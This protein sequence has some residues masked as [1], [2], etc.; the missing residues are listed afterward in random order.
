M[1]LFEPEAA[2]WMVDA[3]PGDF[4]FG[5]IEPDWERMAPFV[6]TAMNR[7]PVSLDAGVKK[8]FCG[9]ESFTPD[10]APVLGEAPE[11]GN[12]FVCSCL[13]CF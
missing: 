8:F 4:S 11:L 13:V 7:V 9:P 5:E 6:D 2:S 12:Y 1:G 3:I 10:L